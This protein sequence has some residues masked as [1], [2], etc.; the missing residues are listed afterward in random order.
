[1]EP[2]NYSYTNFLINE[3]SPYLLQHA[4]NPVNWHAWNNETLQKAITENKPMLVSIGYAACHWCHVM[5]HESFENEEIATLMNEHFICIKIDRE[6]RPDID[7]VYMNAVQLLTGRGGWPLNCFAL[8]NGKPF[9]GGTYF[10][11][12][13]WKHALKSL[14]EMYANDYSK[15]LRASEELTQGINNMEVV[16]ASNEKPLINEIFLTSLKNKIFSELDQQSGGLNGA[17]KFPLPGLHQALLTYNYFSANDK[18]SQYSEVFLNR[19]AAGG[20]Y[21]PVGGGFARYAVDAEWVVPHFEKM[22]YDNAQLISLYAKAYMLLPKAEY[23]QIAEQTIQFITTELQEPEGIFYSS[24]DADSEGEEGKYYVWSFSEFEKLAGTDAASLAEY[25]NLQK[26][27]NWEGSHNVLHVTQTDDEFIA[28]HKLSTE[29]FQQKKHALLKILFTERKKRIRP[30]L[31]D[32]S[33]TTWNALTITALANAYWA[34]DNK[35]YLENAQKAA[36]FII[37]NLISSENVLFRNYKTGKVTIPGFADDYATT[38]EAFLTLYSVSFNLKYLYAAKNLTDAL[39][40]NFYDPNSGFFW[41]TSNNDKPLFTRKMEL[42]DNVTPSS[43]AVIAK[44]LLQLSEIFYD[45]KYHAIAQHMLNQ[46]VPNLKKIPAFHF[47]WFETIIEKVNGYKLL[48]ICGK[49]A[50]NYLSALKGS[51]LP[52]IILIGAFSE[53]STAIPAFKNRFVLGE[54]IAYICENKTCMLPAKTVAEM[55]VQLKK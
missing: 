31:D 4:H 49:D 27:G 36:D 28:K 54:T 41:F 45:E 33:I 6:E 9:Y 25:F 53:P 34:F 18:I 2:T 44:V 16:K 42:S 40:T 30:G 14:A 46:I 17:P 11:T 38:I 20:M 3:T 43:N 51:Y 24:L 39:I 15:I 55:L 22:L 1:M 13:Q 29:E 12:D 5:E 8:P 50:D 37:E 26:N 19:I 7:A 52:N 21:D 35:F 23:K 47:K 48:V 10:R 32:K